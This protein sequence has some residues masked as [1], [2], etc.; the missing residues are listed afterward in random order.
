MEGKHTKHTVNVGDRIVARSLNISNDFGKARQ[1]TRKARDSCGASVARQHT[2]F[3][4]RL[5]FAVDGLLTL[6]D[7]QGSLELGIANFYRHVINLGDSG[8][9]SWLAF[10]IGLEFLELLEIVRSFWGV[11]QGLIQG[12]RLVI[13]VSSHIRIRQAIR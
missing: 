7:V 10:H 1:I 8:K 2:G 3:N 11:R 6:G 12:L 13:Q 9:M 5:L 4:L